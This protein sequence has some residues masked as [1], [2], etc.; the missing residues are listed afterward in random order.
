MFII[1]G[2]CIET[3]FNDLNLVLN[4]LIKTIIEFIPF[5]EQLKAVQKE[6]YSSNVSHFMIKYPTLRVIFLFFKARL[7]NK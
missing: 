6:T 4:L 3:S 7:S 1:I 5:D 2:T